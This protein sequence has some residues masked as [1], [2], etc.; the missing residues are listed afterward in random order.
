MI[1]GYRGTLTMDLFHQAR[2]IEDRAAWVEMIDYMVSVQNPPYHG[3]PSDAALSL[4]MRTPFHSHQD[5]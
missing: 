4:M 1:A 2:D 3:R 5:A